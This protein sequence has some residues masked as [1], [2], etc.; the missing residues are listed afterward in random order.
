MS[1]Y[2]WTE[3]TTAPDGRE[4][5][6]IGYDEAREEVVMFGGFDA[7]FVPTGFSDETWVWDGSWTQKSPATVPEGRSNTDL[8]WSAADGGLIMFGGNIDGGFGNDTWLWDGTDWTELFPSNKPTATT[9]Y[10]L[11][12]ATGIG[13]VLLLGGRTPVS[14]SNHTWLW[15]GTNWTDMGAFGTNDYDFQIGFDRARTQVVMYG[16]HVGVS[17][18]D[19]TYVW[20]GA[21]WTLTEAGGAPGGRCCAQL[22]YLACAEM[23]FLFGGSAGAGVAPASSWLWNGTTWIDAAPDV[24][25][26][27][28]IYP[29]L[30]GY[31]ASGDVVYLTDSGNGGETWDF[32]C[33]S[34]V[35][36]NNLFGLGQ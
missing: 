23:L 3:V 30:G 11:A 27:A 34:G 28:M 2:E 14:G 15:D 22:S 12:T 33:I 13:N 31:E 18:D 16:G 21:T 8:A 4:G 25:P 7:A 5:G 36:I 19:D 6:V 10:K 26:P 20:D 1:V 9:Y 32:D 29:N 35:A 24:E 17:Y